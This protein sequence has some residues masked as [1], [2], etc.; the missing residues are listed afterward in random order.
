MHT[1]RHSNPNKDLQRSAQELKKRHPAVYDFHDRIFIEAGRNA[2]RIVCY[3][4]SNP[5]SH[6]YFRGL[7]DKG[8]RLERVKVEGPRTWATKPSTQA[9][10]GVAPLQMP[11][12]PARPVKA[13]VPV[14]SRWTKPLRSIGP[15]EVI[16][17]PDRFERFN[18]K[19]RTAA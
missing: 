18:N 10:E 19:H 1:I 3:L 4:N 11:S 6:K 13:L 15:Q 2:Y 9:V 5:Y 16:L 8:Y 7:W 17:D 12:Q 14:R